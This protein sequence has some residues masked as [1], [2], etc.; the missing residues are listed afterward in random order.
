MPLSR[1]S[2]VVW[3]TSNQ[4]AFSDVASITIP[5]ASWAEMDGTF[6]NVKGLS[7]QFSRAIP[8]PRG[9]MPA[10]Q[11]IGV[12]ARELG[13]DLSLDSVDAV[14]RAMKA[15]VTSTSRPPSMRPGVHSP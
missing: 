11:A 3:L 2:T 12:I 14:R 6:V 1:L 8:A 7:Q 9:V 10:W 13:E 15:S 5:V 4:G